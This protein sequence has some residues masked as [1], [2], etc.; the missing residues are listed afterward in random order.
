M[1]ALDAEGG[2]RRIAITARR[3]IRWR[4][5]GLRRR[6][7]YGGCFRRGGQMPLIN[8]IHCNFCNLAFPPGWGGYT[9]VVDASGKRI[10]CPHPVESSRV[11]DVTGLDWWEARGK[12]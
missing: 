4:L 10:V 8:I 2:L 6:Q 3:L 9:Y 11:K 1:A 7:G 12:G 5:K